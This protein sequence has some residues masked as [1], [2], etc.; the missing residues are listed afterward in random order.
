MCHKYSRQYLNSKI[1]LR[2]YVPTQVHLYVFERFDLDTKA[3]FCGLWLSKDE[4]T[5]G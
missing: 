4:K 2:L 5:N 1:P 3:A